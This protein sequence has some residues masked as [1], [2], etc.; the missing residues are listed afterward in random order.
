[1]DYIYIYIHFCIKYHN[2]TNKN[3]QK[4]ERNVGSDPPKIRLQWLIDLVTER[5]EG[6]GNIVIGTPDM[7]IVHK[8]DIIYFTGR[9][10]VYW[11]KGSNWKP[12]D[13]YW[14]FIGVSRLTAIGERGRERKK[15]TIIKTPRHFLNAMMVPRL[16]TETIFLVCSVWDWVIIPMANVYIRSSRIIFMIAQS[17]TCKVH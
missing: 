10:V 6:I 15:E 7:L 14:S 8:E 13:A 3:L 11:E 16:G 2:L 5:I 17:K 9:T 12:H 4:R 1:M